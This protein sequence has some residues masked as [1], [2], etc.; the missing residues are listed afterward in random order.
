MVSPARRV[1]LD[2]GLTVGSF[3]GVGVLCAFL[4]EWAWTAPRGVVV[5]GRWVPAL[6]TVEEAL[7]GDFD[8]TAW[9]V[10][11]AA[12]A[13]L[14]A[15]AVTAYLL[16]RAELVTLAAVLVGSS[17]A[18]L[19]MWQVGLQL[20]PPDPEPLARTAE[21]GTRLPAALELS[22]SSALVALPV[23]AMLGLLVVFL[24]TAK[25]D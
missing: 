17:L 21:E 20:G 11:V 9:Y 14:V 22:G 4:W 13:G 15:G 24:G 25:R 3:A 19:L 16:D 8:A 7:R 1:A 23:G 5:D 2:A 12:V 10:V 6:P 18:G